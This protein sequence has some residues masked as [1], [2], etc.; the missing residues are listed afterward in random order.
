MFWVSHVMVKLS[1]FLY[2]LDEC[3]LS[4]MIALVRKKPWVEA[5]F[6]L[7]EIEGS[8]FDGCEALW[9]IYLDFYAELN[10][11]IEGILKATDGLEQRDPA[12]TR[13]LASLLAV[14]LN[15]EPSPLAFSLRQYALGAWGPTKSRT[16]FPA[17]FSSYPRESR[18]WLYWVSRRD[19]AMVAYLSKSLKDP[20]G[21]FKDFMHWFSK[22]RISHGQSSMFLAS[23]PR[24]VSLRRYLLSTVVHFVLRTQPYAIV[25]PALVPDE[26]DLVYL[27]ELNACGHIRPDRVLSARRWLATDPLVRRFALDRDAWGQ[28]E[29][30]SEWR[31][32]WKDHISGVPFWDYAKA[33]GAELDS[34]EPEE[35]LLRV[36]GA[37]TH[38]LPVVALSSWWETMFGNLPMPIP[39]PSKSLFQN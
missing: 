20:G 16:S 6:W 32:N 19:I 39:L 36:Q 2:P 17:E 1:R 22:G 33:V 38:P 25:T 28:T 11:R 4:L 14:F 34:L 31:D 18:K 15:A 21:L 12:R 35:Q 13:M 24:Y 26:E 27:D 30:R 7:W 9:R 37:S 5:A 10:P 3:E 29:W 8:G 23:L